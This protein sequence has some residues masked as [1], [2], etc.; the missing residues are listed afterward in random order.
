MSTRS[1]ASATPTQN[2][3]PHATWSTGKTPGMRSRTPAV[4]PL[5]ARMPGSQARGGVGGPPCDDHAPASS[6]PHHRRRDRKSGHQCRG[7]QVVRADH[8]RACARDPDLCPPI[9]EVL[10]RKRADR[11]ADEVSRRDV[12]AEQHPPAR[13][14]DPVIQLVVLVRR[15]RLVV[16]TDA[17]ERTP[18][19]RAGEDGR[20]ILRP[21]RISV[22]SPADAEGRPHRGGDRPSGDARTLAVRATADIVRTGF[23]EQ[24]HATFGDDAVTIPRGRPDAR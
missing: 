16:Q 7:D 24:L 14:A 8:A 1:T 21:R 3:D 9:P 2:P 22:A 23:D 11:F 6:G 17:Q 10:A 18:A 13:L 19:K 12:R 15:V 4:S 20:E 5:P